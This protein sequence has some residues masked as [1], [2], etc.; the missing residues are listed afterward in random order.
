[1]F[2]FKTEAEEI[3]QVCCTNV[4]QNAEGM[5]SL[6]RTSTNGFPQLRLHEHQFTD[7]MMKSTASEIPHSPHDSIQTIAIWFYLI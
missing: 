1:M 4:W 5:F 6:S 7:N 3:V 2:V